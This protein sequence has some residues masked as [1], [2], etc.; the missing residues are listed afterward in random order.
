MHDGKEKIGEQ[1]SILPVFRYPSL[2]SRRSHIYQRRLE[3][4]EIWVIAG[5]GVEEGS[6]V[7]AGRHGTA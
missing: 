7:W 2:E 5:G 1:S 4:D 3:V 6:L